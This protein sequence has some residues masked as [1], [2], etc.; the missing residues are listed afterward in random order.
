MK[1]RPPREKRRPIISGVLL[2]GLGLFLLL[3]S[4]DILDPEQAWPL[5]IMVVGGAFIATAVTKKSPSG[6]QQSPPPQQ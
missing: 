4:H 6:E 2:I 5:L 1:Q 3:T